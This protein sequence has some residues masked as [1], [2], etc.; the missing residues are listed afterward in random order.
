M[1]LALR[2]LRRSAVLLVVSFGATVTAQAMCPVE[3]AAAQPADQI[4]PTRLLRRVTLALTGTTPSP[5]AYQAVVAAGDAAAKQAVI[6]QT[7]DS[8]L[9]SP[10]FYEQMVEFGHDWIVNSEYITGA[11]GDAYQGN[12]S[13][14]L[15]R[16]GSTSAHPN[17]YVASYD[18]PSAQNPCSDKDFSG[19]AQVFVEK[20]VEPW[21]APG[22]QVTVIG[23]AADDVRTLTVKGQTVDCGLASGGYY[24][25]AVPKGCG[26]GPNLVWCTPF[27]GLGS[28]GSG[29]AW[30]QQRQAY[31]EPA[32][33]FAHLAW[34]DRPLSDLVLGNYSV[35][36]NQLRALY[37]RFGRQLGTTSLDADTSWW[38]PAQDT[39]PR[40]PSHPTANDPLAWREFV[41]DTL[42]PPLLSLTNHQRSGDLSRSFTHDPRTTKAQPE[43]VAAAGV[44]TM[45]GTNSSFSRERPRAARFLEMFACYDFQPPPANTPFPLYD[46][47]DPAVSGT[48]LHCHRTIDPVAIAFK[49]W[50]FGLAYYVPWPFLPGVGT[51]AVTKVQLSGQYPYSSMPYM[52]W[53]N[54]WLANT[55]LTPLTQAQLD[56]NPDAI[57]FNT[58][59]T[60]STVLGV[61]PDGTTG[62]LGFGKVLINSGEFDRCAVRK[63]YERF[64]GRPLDAGLERRYIDT[65]AKQFVSNDRKLRP[66][67]KYLLST[68]EF[69]RGL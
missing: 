40:D 68:P 46:G 28:P 21:W 9:A 48:C 14:H 55:V 32:R 41:V 27:D 34:Y 61:H 22:T 37:L 56:D 59:P 39:S 26:C 38:K 24:D 2:R 8:A 52:R 16:C 25:P 62:P 20:K 67:V 13:G 12:M 5:D 66:F 65:L 63:I 43:G 45:M 42:A 64:V 35:A 1:F 49:R 33:L 51:N 44:L 31:D 53:K 36:P 10:A 50:D 23:P 3:P 4:S 18:D 17:A 11:I 30:S 69:Q 29:V 58:M 7:V 6:D 15:L 47:K 19:A 60:D 57:F 54:S